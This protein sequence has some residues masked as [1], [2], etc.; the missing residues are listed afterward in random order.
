MLIL[1]LLLV[2]DLPSSY[3]YW[4]TV[5]KYND[6]LDLRIQVRGWGGGG[7]GGGGGGRGGFLGVFLKQ[8]HVFNDD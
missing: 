5:G 4:E 6:Q 7:G 2:V 8:L 3:C 1:F